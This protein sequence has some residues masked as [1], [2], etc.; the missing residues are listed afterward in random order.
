MSRT[1]QHDPYA[2]KEKKQQRGNEVKFMLFVCHVFQDAIYWGKPFTNHLQSFSVLSAFHW[3]L[4]WRQRTWWKTMV[5]RQKVCQLRVHSVP[6]N[7]VEGWTTDC[8]TAEETVDRTSNTARRVFCPGNI[9]N[10]YKKMKKYTNFKYTFMQK[11][12]HGTFV[13]GFNELLI[14]TGFSRN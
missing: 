11:F 14:I 4:L 12:V 2:E 8:T 13:R 7:T 1:P 6:N 10:E 3:L 5:L 9:L